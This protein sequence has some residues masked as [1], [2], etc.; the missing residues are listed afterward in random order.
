MQKRVLVDTQIVSYAINGDREL[1]P[2]AFAV[3]SVTA[4]ELLLFQGRKADR[5]NYYVPFLAGDQS[6]MPGSQIGLALSDYPPRRR[7]RAGQAATDRFVLDFGGEYP[8]VVEYSHVA[9]ARLLNQGRGD[10][11]Q[12]YARILGAD[13]Y[14]TMVKRLR[15]LL[16]YDIQCRALT[17]G[18]AETALD[19]FAAFTSKYALKKNFR[20]SLN[21]LLSL[22]VAVDSRSR[23]RTEDD[24]LAKFASAYSPTVIDQRDNFLDLDFAR[25]ISRRS[26]A[27]SKGYVNRGWGIR[28]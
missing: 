23:F 19:M 22:A 8:T 20:N 17:S 7:S 4:Q 18:A 28:Y 25:P 5:N 21:D 2:G 1:T 10:V 16:E 13:R 24:L 9:L 15:F 11:I 26:N 12:S 14:R 6:G 27:G 3:T